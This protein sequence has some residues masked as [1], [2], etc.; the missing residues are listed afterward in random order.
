[1]IASMLVVANWGIPQIFCGH[2]AMGRND[3]I[4]AGVCAIVKNDGVVASVM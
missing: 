2:K 1:M 3:S 4:K